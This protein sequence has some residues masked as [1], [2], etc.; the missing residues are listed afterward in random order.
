MFAP[1][2]NFVNPGC[3]IRAIF[4]DTTPMKYAARVIVRFNVVLKFY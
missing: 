3:F 4:A 2:Q 1:V